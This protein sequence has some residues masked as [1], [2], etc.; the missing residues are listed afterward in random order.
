MYHP[1][2]N[3]LKLVPL[4]EVPNEEVRNHFLSRNTPPNTPFVKLSWKPIGSSRTVPADSWEPLENLSSPLREKWM[5]K[6]DDILPTLKKHA[7]EVVVE[8]PQSICKR[9]RKLPPA[10]GTK[11]ENEKENTLVKCVPSYPEFTVETQKGDMRMRVMGMKKGNFG[12]PSYVVEQRLVGSQEVH[13]TSIPAYILTQD[14][15]TP[16]SVLML[17]HWSSN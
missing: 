1:V 10:T 12:L 3:V 4:Q 2:K 7:R 13:Q 11:D 16:L 5:R 6:W 15:R 9:K 8:I 17:N 14:W